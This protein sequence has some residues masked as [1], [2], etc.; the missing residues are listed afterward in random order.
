MSMIRYLRIVAVL[1][2]LFVALGAFG[3]HGLEGKVDAKGLEVWRTAVLYHAL[4]T[5]VLFTLVLRGTFAKGVFWCFVV[6]IAIFSGSLY[7][8]VL[9]G[10][11]WLGMVTPLGG[12]SFLAGWL[13][14][15]LKPR[16]ALGE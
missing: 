9:T 6:G 4:H 12:L 14:L 1:G 16:A 3:A 2:F 5:L 8:H 10:Q 13:W 15:A 7:L 11:R